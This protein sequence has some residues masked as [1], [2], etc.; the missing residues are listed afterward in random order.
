MLF[1]L[2]MSLYEQRFC[3]Y[4]QLSQCK[5]SKNIGIMQVHIGS[6]AKYG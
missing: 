6:F 3:S 2:E 4:A 5:G 1:L